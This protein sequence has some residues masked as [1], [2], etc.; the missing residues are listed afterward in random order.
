MFASIHSSID[1]LSDYLVLVFLVSMDTVA[2][3]RSK[4]DEN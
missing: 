2:S 3:S 1:N 4:D